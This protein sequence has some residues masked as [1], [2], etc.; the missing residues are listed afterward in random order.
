MKIKR[1]YLD[2]I[3]YKPPT[4]RNKHAIKKQMKHHGFPDSEIW[5][6][7]LTMIELLYERLCRYTDIAP[8]DTN[9]HTMQ[10]KGKIYTQHQMIVALKV[11]CVVYLNNFNDLTTL[12]SKQLAEMNDEIWEIWKILAPFMWW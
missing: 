7:D 8:V 4:S 9:Y 6:I 5:N 10:Y 3:G 2:D 12:E 1:F 11:K